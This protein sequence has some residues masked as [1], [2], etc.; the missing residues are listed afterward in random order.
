MFA[1]VAAKNTFAD[2][3]PQSERSAGESTSPERRIRLKQDVDAI[4]KAEFID[5]AFD[6][7]AQY[8]S[9]SCQEL[10]AIDGVNVKAKFERMDSNAFTCTI[11]K[12]LIPWAGYYAFHP[13]HDGVSIA[14]V[15]AKEF[16]TRRSQSNRPTPSSRSARQHSEPELIY[17]QRGCGK[18]SPKTCPS[19]ATRA[20]AQE[21]MSNRQRIIVER[22]AHRLSALGIARRVKNGLAPTDIEASTL[23]LYS[24]K[25]GLSRRRG[26]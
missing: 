3:P 2:A 8:F 17:S 22:C 24:T 15:E 7:M 1:C 12:W 25:S 16:S 10:N 11:I 13:C 5:D 4:Q 18:A 19:P 21:P 14:E 23:A 9:D 6:I 20:E 26:R